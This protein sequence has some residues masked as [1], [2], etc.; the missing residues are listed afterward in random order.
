MFA[1]RNLRTL[2]QTAALLGLTLAVGAAFA[3]STR[4]AATIKQ[5]N[6]YLAEVQKNQAWLDKG[7]TPAEASAVR[8]MR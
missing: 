7:Y 6:R 3:L 4:G 1:H 5:A 8:S 2:L